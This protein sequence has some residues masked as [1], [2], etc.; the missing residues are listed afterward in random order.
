M[1]DNSLKSLLKKSSEIRERYEDF[2]IEKGFSKLILGFYDSTKR[3]GHHQELYDT[4]KKQFPNAS[5]SALYPDY[6]VYKEYR[7]WYYCLLNSIYFNPNH[8]F[9]QDF[10]VKLEIMLSVVKEVVEK[11]GSEKNGAQAYD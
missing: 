3:T 2:A 8:A 1:I 10:K 6:I 5:N 7:N 11:E 4:F 9:Y